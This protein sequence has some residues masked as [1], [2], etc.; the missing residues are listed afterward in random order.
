MAVIFMLLDI[1][2]IFF[3]VLYI[4]RFIRAFFMR[5]K[6][7]RQIKKICKEQKHRLTVHRSPIASLFRLSKKTDLTIDAYTAIYHVKF[8]T[9]LSHKKIYHFVDSHNYI[10]Y[11]KLYFALPFAAEASES[12]LFP[13]FRRFKPNIPELGE[14]EKYILLFNPMPND[15]T[16]VDKN[17]TRQ[18]ASNGSAVNQLYIYNGKGF[19]ELIA[20]NKN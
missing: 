3:A 16:Y 11:L 10:T 6:L 18:V 2:I 20:D 19:C 4:F 1:L 9:A 17:G 5:V 13:S 8:F 12:L 15:V 7:V 14:K